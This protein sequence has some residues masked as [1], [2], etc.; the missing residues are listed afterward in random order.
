M[1]ISADGGSDR[2]RG[3]SDHHAF[4]CADV[5]SVADCGL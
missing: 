5:V 2:A 1:A 3:I 4:G